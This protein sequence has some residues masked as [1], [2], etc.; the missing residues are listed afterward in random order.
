MS[1]IQNT[2]IRSSAPS[3][4]FDVRVECLT[5]DEL[6]QLKSILGCR[7]GDVNGLTG[8]YRAVCQT[9]RE[10]GQDEK[11]YTLTHIGSRIATYRL[12]EIN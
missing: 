11:K 9:L 6:Q 3:P 2:T 12:M 10:N 1:F 7:N 4:V 8:I 5:L